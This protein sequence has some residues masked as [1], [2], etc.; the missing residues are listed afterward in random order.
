MATV[1]ECSNV[2]RVYK[3]SKSK[4]REK[5]ETVALSNLCFTVPGGIVFGLLGPNGSGKT[6]TIR[7]LATLLTPTSGQAKVFGFDVVRDAPKVR[8]RIGLIFGGERGLYGRL[9]GIENLR[10]FAAL[11]HMDANLTQRRIVEVLDIVGLSGA[12]DRLVEQYSRGMRQRLHIARGILADPDLIF[13][14]EPTIGI[15][16]QGAQEIRQMVP[17]FARRGKTILLTTHYMFEADE[18]SNQIAIINKG[19]IIASGSPSEIKRKFSKIVAFEVA[20]K[21]MNPDTVKNLSALDGVIRVTSSSDGPI[22]KLTINV[23][24]DSGIEGLVKSIIGQENIES[25]VKR[26]PTLE[27]A[28]LSIIK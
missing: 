17:E 12:S 1:I 10:Y 19:E 15:D 25:F 6:T 8:K 28:Y 9:T 24:P 2:R 18:I 7:I 26:D 21:K 27:E 11:S 5:G 13:M 16:P 23:S 20:L 3:G 14:D 4:K 22:Q